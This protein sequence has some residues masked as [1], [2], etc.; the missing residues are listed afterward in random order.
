MFAKYIAQPYI[1]TWGLSWAYK[2]RFCILGPG[3]FALE[4][5][6]ECFGIQS[7]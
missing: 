1:C 5:G 6:K 7:H 3:W 4:F 2:G